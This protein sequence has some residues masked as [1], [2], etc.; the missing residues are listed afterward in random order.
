MHPH[1]SIIADPKRGPGRP[2]ADDTPSLRARNLRWLQSH[3]YYRMSI[4]AIAKGERDEVSP[5]TV[6]RGIAA[7]RRYATAP[8]GTLRRDPAEDDA[9]DE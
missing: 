1:G 9:D 8:R 3:I 7:A 2:R 4:S 6:K 5:R